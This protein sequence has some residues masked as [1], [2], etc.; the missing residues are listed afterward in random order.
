MDLNYYYLNVFCE[1]DLFRLCLDVM[2]IFFIGIIYWVVIRFLVV[3]NL[4]RNLK[5]VFGLL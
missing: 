4:E 5:K 2:V 3:N 1:F